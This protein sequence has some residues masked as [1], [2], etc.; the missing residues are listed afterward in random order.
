[1]LFH[2]S[3][4]TF[5][6]TDGADEVTLYCL[7]KRNEMPA[8][9]EEIAEA[10]EEGVKVVNSVGPKRIIEKKGK[11]AGV[12]FVKCVSVFDA[13]GKF[14]PVYDENVVSEADAD[15]VLVAVG[16]SIVWGDLL[17]GSKVELN[18]NNTA[19]ADGFTYQ[20]AEPDVF[21]G[22]DVYTGPKFAIDAIAA[23]KQ[24]AISLHRFVQPGQSLVIG[25]DRREYTALDKSNVAT[26]GYDRAPRQRAGHNAAND[27]TFR[28][29]R[30]TFTEE[31]M[32][33]ETERCLGCGAVQI[34]E[35]MCVG[36]GMCVTKC[37]FDAIHLVKRYDGHGTTYEKL[38]MKMAGYMAK[39]TG[40]I[41]ARSIKD[42]FTFKKD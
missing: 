34:D 9:E 35:Y 28:D 10:E 17:K 27:K 5:P 15:C 23:G 8:L 18:R 33:K 14:A 12:E 42:A 4:R 37:N 38:P 3:A 13:D 39:R 6:T 29:N 25:R 32:K 1:M 30:L 31:Q 40:K 2:L 11:A 26:D 16:Q 22:G 36:C 21:V 41:I 7:E 24:G 20:T 19:K